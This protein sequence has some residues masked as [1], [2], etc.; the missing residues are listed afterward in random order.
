MWFVDC[1]CMSV[2]PLPVRWCF[3]IGEG[4]PEH[5]WE[6]PSASAA[7]SATRPPAGHTVWVQ[8]RYSKVE[9]GY[10]R[11]AFI[12]PSISLLNIQLQC[13]SHCFHC[14]VLMNGLKKLHSWFMSGR[15]CGPWWYFMNNTDQGHKRVWISGWVNL[16]RSGVVCMCEMS[17]PKPEPWIATNAAYKNWR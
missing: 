5:C 10:S 6:L 12:I 1:S 2:C 7:M 16:P 15:T 14:L 9:G 3:C 17:A 13:I 4:P 11:Y 8:V